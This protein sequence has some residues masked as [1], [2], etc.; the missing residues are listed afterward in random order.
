LTAQEPASVVFFHPDGMGVNTWAA[1][2][3]AT[4]GPDGRLNWDRLTQSAVYLGHMKDALASTSHGGA[5]VHA[6]GVKV[7][8]DSYGMDGGVPLVA[9]SRAPMSILMEAQQRAAAVGIVNSAR[10]PSPD[11]RVRGQ[12]PGPLRSR[13]I[14]RQISAPR[15]P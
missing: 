3:V 15:R 1:V 9:R 13:E 4:V 7:A 8:H 10:S 5:T 12:C 6:F 2:R 11:G 14:V